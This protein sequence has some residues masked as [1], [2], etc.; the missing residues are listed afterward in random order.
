MMLE[1][2]QWVRAIGLIGVVASTAVLSSCGGNSKGGDPNDSLDRHAL[3]QSW[4]QAVLAPSYTA[5]ATEARALQE[6]VETYQDAVASAS[7]T[8]EQALLAAQTAWREAMVGWQQLELMQVG[9][10]GSSGP[11]GFKGGQDL[12]DEIYSWPTVSPCRV[13]QE[14]VAAGYENS[15]FFGS[16]TVNAY[17][18]DALEYL[19]FNESLEHTC[20]VQ[21]ELDEGWSQLTE[22]QI[23]ER[24]SSYAL[25][26]TEYVVQVAESLEVLWNDGNSGF[27]VQFTQPGMGDSVYDDTRCA[28][29]EVF[30]ALFY[31]ELTVKDHKLGIPVGVRAECAAAACPEAVESPWAS[32]GKQN[33]LANYQGF[34]LLFWGRDGSQGFDDLL[35][36]VNATDLLARIRT[37]FDAAKNAVEAIPGS[38]E[39]AVVEEHEVALK[40][41][42][43]LRALTDIIKTEFVSTLNLR[44]PAEGA[45][46]ND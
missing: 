1:R 41:H 32:H 11:T 22:A 19:L 9:P 37:Q 17:G 4:A 45:G 12:R 7:E 16:N 34:E 28:I 29:D 36:N 33:L 10:S 31:I 46:D 24:R 25:R 26:L 43:E 8:Q 3:L 42:T 2:D 38:L 13:D 40:A 27:V 30:A 35:V 21:A 39:Q 18:L 6:A 44:V 15:E 14:L 23:R 5:F 20:P